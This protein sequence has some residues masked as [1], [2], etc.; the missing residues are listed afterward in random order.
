MLYPYFLNDF[1]AVFIYHFGP[2]FLSL[3]TVVFILGANP[4]LLG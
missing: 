1:F 2:D 4:L 3:H